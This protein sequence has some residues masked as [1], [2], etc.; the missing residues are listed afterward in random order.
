[1]SLALADALAAALPLLAARD[2]EFATSLLNAARSPRGLTDR[3]VYW[4]EK[5]IARA[6]APAAAPTV[7]QV[8][9]IIELLARAGSRLKYPKVRLATE[10]GQR[11]VLSVAGERSRYTG[12]VM[13]T[14][15]GPFGANTYFG[16]IA[17]DGTVTESG[18][19]TPEVMALL[20]SFAAEPAKVGAKIGKMLGACC[21]CSRQLDTRE[22]LAV[23]YGPVCADK[24]GLPWG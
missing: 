23:G 10:S 15:G 3:Q 6:S 18:A 24:Y 7:V 19:M 11:V 8:G 12:S 22:S 5:L 2:V 17:P 21:F 4:A 14:D 13:V 16:R 20:V 9:G 1:M